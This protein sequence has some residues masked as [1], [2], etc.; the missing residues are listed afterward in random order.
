MGKRGP[1][2]QPSIVKYV[3]G[4]PGKRAMNSSEP[5]PEEVDA[6]F[7]PPGY[8]SGDGL[9][10]WY[11]VLP[12]LIGMRVMTNADDAIN[13]L[14]EQLQQDDMVLVK[15]SRAIGMERIVAALTVDDNNKPGSKHRH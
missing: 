4:N 6:D 11:Q 10:K 8:L 2:P 13:L 5:T 15:G 7:P 14:N 1:A 3:R 12:I 9:E